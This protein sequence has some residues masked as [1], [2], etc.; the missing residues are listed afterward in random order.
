MWYSLFRTSL[1][2]GR[3]A[4]DAGPRGNGAARDTAPWRRGKKGPTESRAAKEG[5]ASRS[6]RLPGSP[7]L[8]ARCRHVLPLRL[9]GS[10]C[11]GRRAH[12][13]GHRPEPP[14]GGRWMD[15]TTATAGGVNVPHCDKLSQCCK[16]VTV[17]WPRTTRRRCA[18]ATDLDLGSNFVPRSSDGPRGGGDT[19][20]RVQ[21]RAWSLRQSAGCAHGDRRSAV[22]RAVKS[23]PLISI[24]A[25]RGTKTGI[26]CLLGALPPGTAHRAGRRCTVRDAPAE[27]RRRTSSSGGRSLRPNDSAVERADERSDFLGRIGEDGGERCVVDRDVDVDRHTF[28]SG[29]G[30]PRQRRLDRGELLGQQ[31]RIAQ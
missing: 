16:K 28:V 6:P 30:D 14:F 18:F 29:A 21:Q 19:P 1:R 26:A 3:P 31:Q 23:R 7:P 11:R 20:R 27:A 15:E 8:R 25:F 13:A 5:S 22:A 2:P 9:R 4:K 17:K 24:N 12:A 10:R